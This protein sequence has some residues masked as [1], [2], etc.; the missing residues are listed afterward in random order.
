MTTG[1][2]IVTAQFR[3]DLG[4]HVAAVKTGAKFGVVCEACGP[5]GDDTHAGYIA[6]EQALKHSKSCRKLPR[7]LWVEIPGTVTS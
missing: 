7:R 4:L 6:D 2:R 3:N 5:V 1:T